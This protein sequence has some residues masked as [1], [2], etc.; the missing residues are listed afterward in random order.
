MVIRMGIEPIAGHCYLCDHTGKVRIVVV[1]QGIE[2]C[3]EG[4]QPP[5]QTRYT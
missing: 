5:M 1:S 2:P 3:P 4:L